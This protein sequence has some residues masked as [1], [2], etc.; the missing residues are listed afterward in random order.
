[1]ACSLC[2]NE[3]KEWLVRRIFYLG[4]LSCEFCGNQTC[5]SYTYSRRFLQSN[6]VDSMNTRFGETPRSPCFESSSLILD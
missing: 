4:Q 5:M 6:T 3:N 1:M 2:G